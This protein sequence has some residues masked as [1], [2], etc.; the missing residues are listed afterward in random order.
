MGFLEVKRY[1]VICDK[2]NC[3]NI[4][5]VF[6]FTESSDEDGIPVEIETPEYTGFLCA[7]LRDAGWQFVDDKVIC[8]E[9]EPNM[10]EESLFAF[11]KADMGI[12]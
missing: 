5:V 12:I 9:C 4:Y 8:P 6:D 11:L 2:N 3:D 10:R 7:S 1:H